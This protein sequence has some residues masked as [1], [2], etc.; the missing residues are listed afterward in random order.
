MKRLPKKRPPIGE[1]GSGRDMAERLGLS[2]AMCSRLRSGERL[3]SYQ[4]LSD[5]SR[6]YRIDRIL[7]LDACIEGGKAFSKLLRDRGV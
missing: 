1:W 2:E 7:L 5:I 6:E 3:P 4:T